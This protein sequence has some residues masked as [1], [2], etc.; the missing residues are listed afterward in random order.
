M[1]FDFTKVQFNSGLMLSEMERR[2]ITL[3]V[4]DGTDIVKA[5]YKEHEELLIDVFSSVYPFTTS[6]IV[7]DKYLTKKKLVELGVRVAEGKVFGATK[8][9]EMAE[10]AKEIGYPVVL[11]PVSGGHGEYVFSGIGSEDDLRRKIELMGGYRDGGWILLEKHVNGEEYR[12]FMTE[13]GFLAAVHR[14]PAQVVGD[15]TQSI[16]NLIQKENFLRMNPR[17]NCL[18]EIKLDEVMFEFLRKNSMSLVDTIPENGEMVQLRAS[19]NVSMGGNCVDV[20]DSV[21]ESVRH[22]ATSIMKGFEGMRYIGMDLICEDIT[23]SLIQ[24]QFVVCELNVAPGLSLHMLPAEGQSRNV[25][26]ALVDLLY[27]ET[28]K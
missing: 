28:R 22:L 15:G 27:P 4:I 19:S 3:E 24:Q 10:Y 25:A 18:C 21:H 9:Q 26:A 7:N 8:V 2:G 23:K 12:V 14:T 20:T 5:M 16:L 6:W 1:K 13:Q 11:K 17:Q